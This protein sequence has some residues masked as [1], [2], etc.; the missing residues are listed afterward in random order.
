M[1]SRFAKTPKTPYYVVTFTSQRTESHQKE[2]DEISDIMES[3]AEKQPGYLG[4]ESA[5]DSS[6]LGI[7]LSYWKD[8]ESILNW[9]RNTDH[10]LAQKL[11]KEKFYENYSTRVAKVEHAYEL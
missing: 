7:T 5:R 9:K 10:L 3:L 6:G 4:V 1:S 8:R 2:Y 11:G